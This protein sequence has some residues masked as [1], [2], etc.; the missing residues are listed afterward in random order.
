MGKNTVEATDGKEKHNVRITKPLPQNRQ[1]LTR[2]DEK[3]IQQKSKKRKYVEPLAVKPVHLTECS[4]EN[5]HD[6]NVCTGCKKPRTDANGNTDKPV[7]D[8]NSGR[9]L[10]VEDAIEILTT[11]KKMSEDQKKQLVERSEH[12]RQAIET[13]RSC[14]EDYFRSLKEILQDREESL[15]RKLRRLEVFSSHEEAMTKVDSTLAELDGLLQEGKKVVKRI[16][17]E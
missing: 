5:A 7:S 2:S 11:L 9:R 15:R 16:F 8:R 13:G 3:V 6:E 10:Q 17:C 4:D 1:S 12:T 14:I